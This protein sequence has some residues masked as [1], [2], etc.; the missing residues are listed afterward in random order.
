MKKIEHIWPLTIVADRYGGVYSGGRYL[1]FNAY[2]D[3]LPVEPFAGDIP[4]MD[5]WDHQN[6]YQARI[7]GVGWT[8]DEA[9]E[10]LQE[11]LAK[12]L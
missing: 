10:S 12:Q 3:E 1:A 2:P 8:L 5:F 11:Q 4:C 9:L 7:I 6:D